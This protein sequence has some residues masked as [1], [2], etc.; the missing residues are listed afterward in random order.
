VPLFASCINNSYSQRSAHAINERCHHMPEKQESLN[1]SPTETKITLAD[2]MKSFAESLSALRD[3]VDIVSSVLDEQQRKFVEEHRAG[4]AP[5]LIAISR[6]IKNPKISKDDA[7]KME[8][9]LG[10]KVKVTTQEEGGVKIEI[11]G[12]DDGLANQM[13]E[14][15]KGV[16]STTGHQRLLYRSALIS[17]ISS[18]EWFLS[19]VIRQHL[20]LHSPGRW[21]QRE[22]AQPRGP[23]NLGIHRRSDEVFDRFANR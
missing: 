12:A 7:E 14:A 2:S 6:L 16:K 13:V 4:L 19:Q 1:L 11:E 15:L 5:L 22:S 17:L 8:K 21:R 18:A 3:F 23:E 20:V 10:D 9:E